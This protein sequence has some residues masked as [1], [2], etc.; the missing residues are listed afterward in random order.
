MLKRKA[1]AEAALKKQ[2]ELMLRE[3]EITKQEE[4]VNKIINQA[5][6]CFY[7]R[8]E[9]QKSRLSGPPA[10]GSMDI[11]SVVTFAPT[12]T[13]NKSMI[14]DKT[15]SSVAEE[16]SEDEQQV[17]K[18]VTITQ[19]PQMT[20]LY[21]NESF[22]TLE[23][24]SQLNTAA[25]VIASS[26]PLTDSNKAAT[27]SDISDSLKMSDSLTGVFF[28]LC[29]LLFLRYVACLEISACSK[30]YSETFISPLDYDTATIHLQ[31]NVL[32]T[33]TYNKTYTKIEH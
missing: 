29:V 13:D 16:L 18:T 22:E 10:L 1:A 25:T 32:L 14:E 6:E 5:M 3:Q 19:T 9:A 23:I 8:K 11:S 17:V 21:G 12:K 4:E 28:C 30:M 15:I 24:T 2:Q 27:G 31:L 26:T 20:E 7:Q 33:K